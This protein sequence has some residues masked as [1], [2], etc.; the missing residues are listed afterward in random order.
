MTKRTGPTNPMTVGLIR[1]LKKLAVKENVN[2]WKDIA[3]FLGKSSRQRPSVNLG[4]LDKFYDGKLE[5]IVPGKVLADGIITKPVK[6]SAFSVSSSAQ[7]KLKS[8]KGSFTTLSD[9]MKKN[10]KG[11]NLRIIV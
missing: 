3:R 11:K 5:L 6:V 2:I 10:P 9:L 8:V 7:D 4:K 1:D